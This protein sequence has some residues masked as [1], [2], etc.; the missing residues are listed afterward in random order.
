MRNFLFAAS[1]AERHR[2]DFFGLLAIAPRGFSGRLRLQFEEFRYGLL[3][4]QHRQKVALVEYEHY[5]EL[6]A[7]HGHQEGKELAN[8]LEER[9]TSCRLSVAKLMRV[10]CTARGRANRVEREVGG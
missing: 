6:L 2:K 5:F 7:A 1:Y 8:F 4:P 9:L 10:Y 3:L